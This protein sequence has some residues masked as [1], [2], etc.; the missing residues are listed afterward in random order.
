MECG[1]GTFWYKPS[2]DAMAYCES[3][4]RGQYQGSTGQMSCESCGNGL[5]TEM[6]GATGFDMCKGKI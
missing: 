1:A 4:P 5:T 6:M 2:A 3:C